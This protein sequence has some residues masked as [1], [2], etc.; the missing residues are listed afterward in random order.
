M[1]KATA[2]AVARAI[3]ATPRPETSYIIGL[4]FHVH[5]G[6]GCTAFGTK[7]SGTE[8]ALAASTSPARKL[9]IGW[10][11]IG[12]KLTPKPNSR[13]IKPWSRSGERVPLQTEV[14]R[15]ALGQK[16]TSQATPI[17]SAEC[18][19]AVI[20][21]RRRL[22]VMCGDGAVKSYRTPSQACRTRALIVLLLVDADLKDSVLLLRRSVDQPQSASGGTLLIALS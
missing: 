21:M 16:L 8:T 18:Q 9:V 4:S 13:Q 11:G 10:G 6:R 15:S 2:I 12:T 7:A 5:H 22:I 17:K 3:E 19:L 14:K 1:H 20:A